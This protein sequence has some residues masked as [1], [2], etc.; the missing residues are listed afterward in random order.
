[1]K[2][3]NRGDKSQNQSQTGADA[4]SGGDGASSSG[5]A[6]LTSSPSSSNDGNTADNTSMAVSATPSQS[7]PGKL[8]L[9]VAHTE[10]IEK[11]DGTRITVKDEASLTTDRENLRSD[12]DALARG[13]R[14]GVVATPSSLLPAKEDNARLPQPTSPNGASSDTP[15]S[16]PA[17]DHS[18]SGTS[19]HSEE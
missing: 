19:S 7:Q 11:P 18:N 2:F 8:D 13:L 4:T 16:N 3:W 9:N 17:S 6:Q 5:S 1:M 14:S 15:N 10:T 12:T